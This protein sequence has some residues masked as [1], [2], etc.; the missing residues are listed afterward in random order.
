MLYQ[1]VE[2]QTHSQDPRVNNQDSLSY[3]RKQNQQTEVVRR[4][5]SLFTLKG[6]AAGGVFLS[7][8]SNRIRC[9]G[10]QKAMEAPQLPSGLV[11]RQKAEAKPFQLVSFS[12]ST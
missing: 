8:P 3:N 6:F 9:R 10:R 1:Q 2:A 11:S 12:R 7:P 5:Q 4:P